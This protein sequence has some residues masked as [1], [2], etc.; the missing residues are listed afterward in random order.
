MALGKNLN[1]ILGDYFGDQVSLDDNSGSDQNN[2]VYR[3]INVEQRSSATSEV[4]R[5]S[6]DKIVLNPYQT[7]TQFDFEK[8]QSL[9]NSIKENGLLSPIIVIKKD[10]HYVLIAGE[11]R[12]RATKLL[13]ET[14]ILAF[15][16]EE[17]ELTEQQQ[18][19]ITATEN[20]QREDLSPIELGYTYK[21]IMD[22]LQIDEKR[23]GE[24]LGTTTQYVKNY[25]R[26]LTLS[27]PVQKA[28]LEKKIGEGHARHLVG[29][30][31]HQQ[32]AMVEIII[33]RDLSVREIIEYLRRIDKAADKKQI[34]KV[35]EHLIPRLEPR[36]LNNINNVVN[37]LPN[38]K[39]KYSGNERK[40]KVVI[41][42]K[43]K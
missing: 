3:Q 15:V 13:N 32:E 37:N 20:L 31:E 22:A 9:A 12:L 14:E 2:R 4:R 29:L 39:V 19:M 18:V 7:R 26:L 6:V 36:I 42:W 16:K 23:L 30:P 8:I 38:A 10:D 34:G 11:R 25:L 43:K 28:L 35:K 17:N 24:K 33:E 40:G 5:I 1:N 41:S 21:S 27:R